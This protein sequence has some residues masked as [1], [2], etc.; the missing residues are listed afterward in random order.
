MVW[1]LGLGCLWRE[2]G[3]QYSSVGYWERTWALQR[4]RGVRIGLW[5]SPEGS[6]ARCRGNGVI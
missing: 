3:D 4:G 2:L 1:E 6:E 5:R